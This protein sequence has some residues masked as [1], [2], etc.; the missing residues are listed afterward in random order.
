MSWTNVQEKVP[1]IHSGTFEVKR[2]NGEQMKCF[3]YADKMM[4]IA[5]YGQKPCH[6]WNAKGNHEPIHDVTE[7]KKI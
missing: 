4:W 1:D 3:F 5:L 7:W 2:Q 6:W